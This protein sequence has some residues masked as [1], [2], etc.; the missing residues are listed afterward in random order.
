MDCVTY[1]QEDAEGIKESSLTAILSSQ[2]RDDLKATRSKDDSDSDPETTVRRER[3]STEGVA[4]SHFPVPCQ[5]D[6]YK[7]TSPYC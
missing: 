3:S 6:R 4:N 2:A 7:F 1:H 5:N